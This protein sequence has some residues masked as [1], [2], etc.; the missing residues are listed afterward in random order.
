MLSL[1]TFTAVPKLPNTCNRLLPQLSSSSAMQ[2]KK[3]PKEK[4][5]RNPPCR[6][7]EKSEWSWALQP[8]TDCN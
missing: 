7:I 2:Q 8:T 4:G 1:Y 5:A 6:E 3:Q